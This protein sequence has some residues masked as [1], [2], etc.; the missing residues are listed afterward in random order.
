MTVK[1]AARWKV[2]STP[3]C[4]QGCP[5]RERCGKLGL[6][7]KAF[8]EYTAHNSTARKPGNPTAKRFDNAHIP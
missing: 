5:D 7:C 6:S 1:Y 4:D 3:P 2:I 8:S